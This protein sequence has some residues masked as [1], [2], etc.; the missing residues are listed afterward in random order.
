MFSK[1]DKERGI[2]LYFG[3]ITDDCIRT[4]RISLMEPQIVPYN[5]NVVE[6]I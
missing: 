6:S 5:V 2:K 4:G 1:F 3:G